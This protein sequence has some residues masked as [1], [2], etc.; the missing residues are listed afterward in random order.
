M[1]IHSFSRLLALPLI[2]VAGYYL[3]LL[4]QPG[5][6]NTVYIF[7]PVVLLTLLYVFHGQIDYWWMQNNPP[8]VDIKIRDWLTTYLPYY[9]TYSETR[10]KEFEKR[11]VL[12]V[13]ARSF[14]SVG[15][16]ELRPVPFD[17]K[18]IIASQA[19]RL[20][21]AQKDFLLGDMDRIFLY[22]HPFPSP[23]HPFL[24]TVE[25][26]EEDGVLIFSSEQGL[27]GIVNPSMYY[28][29][30]LHG[31]IQAYLALHPKLALKEVSAIGWDDLE[32]IDGINSN[33]II[34]TCGFEDLDLRVVNTVAFFEFS[35]QYVVLFPKAYDELCGVFGQKPVSRDLHF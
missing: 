13:E 15:T 26:D 9:N 2:V 16:T 20:T 5:V 17:L 3:Y 14:Q 21:I 25:V 24:H 30:V 12:Y 29:I 32:K 28:N 4:F 31:Y 18:N 27:P 1:K 23:K 34:K 6:N 35:E 33:L 11:L 19:I 10:R 7:I 22:K 8:E